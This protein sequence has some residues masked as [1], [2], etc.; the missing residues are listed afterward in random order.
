MR[1]VFPKILRLVLYLPVKFSS[2]LSG[3]VQWSEG[4]KKKPGSVGDP[5]FEFDLS[6]TFF[7]LSSLA[8]PPW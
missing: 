1:R 6:V 3:G 8:V 4:G 5:V 7:F 2:G